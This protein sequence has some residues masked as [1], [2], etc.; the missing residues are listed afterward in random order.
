MILDIFISSIISYYI[1]PSFIGITGVSFLILPEFLI[2]QHLS[3][4]LTK[5][6]YH[7]Y[8]IFVSVDLHCMDLEDH[9]SCVQGCT[10]N[11][12]LVRFQL[13]SKP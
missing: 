11:S 10:C 1:Y 8:V 9:Y 2:Y 13:G 6:W 12:S 4:L 7:G 5:S 3:S